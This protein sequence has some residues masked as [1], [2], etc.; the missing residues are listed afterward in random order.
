MPVDAEIHLTPV[1][2]RVGHG[3]PVTVHALVAQF[4]QVAAPAG[5]DPAPTLAAA[6]QLG[7]PA[8]GIVRSPG[9]FKFEFVIFALFC[10]DID[11]AAGSVVVEKT[12]ACRTVQ[13]LN[14]FNGHDRRCHIQVVSGPAVGETACQ[15]LFPPVNEHGDTVV[16]VDT[17]D[18]MVGIDGTGGNG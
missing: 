15:I 13:Y 17:D 2:S 12:V 14:T 7:F 18:L 1:H 16:A 8:P 11:H 3:F 5:T 9:S 4:F 6:G 10:N